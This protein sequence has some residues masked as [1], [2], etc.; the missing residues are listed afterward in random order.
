MLHGGRSPDQGV[1]LPAF[2]QCLFQFDQMR[3]VAQHRNRAADRAIAVHNG[4][5]RKIYNLHLPRRGMTFKSLA[6]LGVAGVQGFEQGLATPAGA[7]KRQICQFGSEHV[8][9]IAA[10]MS[11]GG[12]ELA[13]A[14]LG[15]NQNDGL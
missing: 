14:S 3:F 8:R 6:H 12:I 2:L 1:I 4:R 5:C 15:V 9:L 11:S 7:V 13:Q 10:R